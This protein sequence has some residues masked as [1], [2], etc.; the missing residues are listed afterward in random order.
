MIS[1][2]NKLLKFI[3]GLRSAKLDWYYFFDEPLPFLTYF[4]KHNENLSLFPQIEKLLLIFPFEDFEKL[5][6]NWLKHS[7]CRFPD[8]HIQRSP[9]TVNEGRLCFTIKYY[10]NFI[11]ISSTFHDYQLIEFKLYDDKII[12]MYRGICYQ[13]NFDELNTLLKLKCFM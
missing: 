13:T 2:K 12:I 6:K 11:Y 1:L 5:F 7:K 4:K 8:H 3:R 9:F 10:S